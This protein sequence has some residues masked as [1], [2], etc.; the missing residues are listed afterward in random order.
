MEVASYVQGGRVSITRLFQNQNICDF[1]HVDLQMHNPEGEK[2][3]KIDAFVVLGMEDQ[4]I[5]QYP[6]YML[7]DS[8]N[9]DVMCMVHHVYGLEHPRAP[10]N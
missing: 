8:Y 9:L 6:Y 1:G 2:D 3:S 7:K 5:M 4:E 10:F